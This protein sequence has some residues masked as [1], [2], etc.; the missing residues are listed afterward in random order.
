MD[1]HELRTWV[2][3]S[4]ENIVHNYTTFR[5]LI[6]PATKIM[7]VVKSNAYGHGLIDFSRLIVE[8]GVDWL[9]VDSVVEGLRL[10]KEGIVIPILVLGYTLPARVKEAVEA[11]ITLMV[12]SFDT[13]E[14]YIQL[15]L[16]QPVNIHVKVDTGMHRLGFAQHEQNEV[17]EFLKNHKE[18]FNFN[19][20]FTHFAAAKNPADRTFTEKQ[21][22]VFNEWIATSRQAGFTP[23]IHAGATAATLIYPEAQFD[24]VRIGAG[25]YGI[26]PADAIESAKKAELQLKPVLTWKTLLIE[27][28]KVPQGEGIGYDL[29][30][31]LTR[32]SQIAI[33]PIGYW[34]GFPRSLSN[35]GSVLIRGKR[36][37]VLGRVAMDMIVL[38]VTDI[39]DAQV[40]DEVVLIGKDGS[41][42]ITSRD[43]AQLADT[44]AYEILTRLN[45]LLKK[46]I[47]H[48][49]SH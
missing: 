17:M 13:L 39:P 30:T 31:T 35:K 48:A 49:S 20:L 38:D 23:L 2:E 5:S 36:A 24:M 1:L 44:S 25:L 45:P 6:N 16:E 22:N 43:I 3:L 26:W 9:A 37:Q 10:R 15:E 19:G 46:V 8:A 42:E 12:S 40:G 28:K 47:T 7:A 27:K 18:S 4:E 29:S 32:D 14:S 11:D 21:L 41:E 33:C 34:H